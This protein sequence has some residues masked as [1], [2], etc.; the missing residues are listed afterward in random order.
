MKHRG[1]R[2]D[3]S[4]TLLR[5][6]FSGASMLK[7]STMDPVIQDET[8]Q[9]AIVRNQPSRVR[10]ISGAIR[11]ISTIVA[12]VL[13]IRAFVS[14]FEVD[15]RSMS[16]NLHNHDR[17]FVNRA[18]YLHIDINRILNVIPG[19]DREGADIWFPFDTPNRGDIV[20]LNP[21]GD[22]DKP[23]IKRVIGLP[24]ES[25]SFRDGYVYINGQKLNEPYIDGAKTFCEGRSWCSMESIPDGMVFVL[26]DNRPDSE[27]SRFFGPVS[28]D[29]LL[30]K[31]WL[32]NWPLSDAG[33]IPSYDYD[34]V[35][36]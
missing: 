13:L 15:G 26:G 19:V 8:P 34:L 21:P 9:P 35:Q 14:P 3:I 10:R 25:I 31:A 12:I 24:G 36:P 30:G 16:P 5:V 33:R 1:V 11:F 27:D 20:V 4:R 2:V 18:R 17:V 28:V 29:D 23:Y 7:D 32:T 6:P 22:S